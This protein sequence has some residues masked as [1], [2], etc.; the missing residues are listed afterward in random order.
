M[1]KYCTNQG[2][3]NDDNLELSKTSHRL[4]HSKKTIRGREVFL[5]QGDSYELKGLRGEIEEQKIR[6][7]NSEILETAGVR[8]EEELRQS[9]LENQRSQEQPLETKRFFVNTGNQRESRRR[10]VEM[11]NSEL[12]VAK[13]QEESKTR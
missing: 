10:Q 6:I 3:V 9:K 11:F 2:M 1:V 12:E 8:L 13:S 7:N 4:R 5:R